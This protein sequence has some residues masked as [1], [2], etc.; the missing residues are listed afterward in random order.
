MSSSLVWIPANGDAPIEWGADYP[1]RLVHVD[2]LEQTVSRLATIKSPSQLGETA[3]DVTVG[4]RVITVQ[5]RIVGDDMEAYWELRRTLARAL[6]HPRPRGNAVPLLGVLR[7]LREGLLALEIEAAP[8]NSP[9]ISPMARGFPGGVADIELDCPYPYFREI[10]DSSA[11]LQTAGAGLEF[12]TELPME[13]ESGNA[14]QDIV[15]EGDVDA[16]FLARLYGDATTVRLR[17][18]TT[19]EVLEIMGNVPATQYLEVDTEPGAQRVE[20][21]TIATGARQSVMNRLNLAKADL[22]LLRPGANLVAFEADLNPSG[23][24]SLTW[25]RR[26]SGV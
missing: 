10:D 21:V 4:T 17:N 13:V 12:S 22:W 9:Q 6:T 3:V 18:L 24:A 2:G 7:I 5:L 8:R 19:G 23:R 1:Y 20:L 26:Y 16:P 15:N 11:T 25:R 14:T